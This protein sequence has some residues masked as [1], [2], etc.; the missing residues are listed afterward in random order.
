MLTY[1]Y[2]PKDTLGISFDGFRIL[3][4]SNDLT[5]EFHTETMVLNYVDLASDHL[6]IDARLLN[7]VNEYWVHKEE[8]DGTLIPF[9]YE[10]SATAGVNGLTL[11]T[12]SQ[13]AP[14]IPGGDGLFDQGS[15]SYTYY[16]SLTESLVEGSITFEGSSEPV[17]GSAWIDRQYGTFNPHTE[18]KYEWFFLQLSN[19]MDL[20]I[21]NIFTRENQ[22][23]DD[24]AYKHLSVYVDD[25]TQY[26]THDFEL[27][28]LSWAKMPGTENCYA[29]SWRL[30]SDLNQMDLSFSTLHHNSEVL[31]PLNFFEGATTASGTVNDSSVTGI[32]FAELVKNYEEPRIK[33]TRPIKHWNENYPIQ[34]EVENPDD[35]R[36][37][38]FDLTYSTDGSSWIP[39]AESLDD[40]L[41]YWNN[42][43]FVNGDSC[44]FRVEGFTP[45]ETLKAGSTTSTHRLYDDRY[46][47]SNQ[48]VVPAIHIY[49]NPVEN[50]LRIVWGTEFP[51]M[52]AKLSYRIV[53]FTGRRMMQGS[54]SKGEVDVSG[55][56]NGVYLILLHTKEGDSIHKFVKK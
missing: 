8:G 56:K 10:L 14:L 16:Y 51:G 17:S 41:Y 50:T 6:H 38:L 19:G 30:S 21:W 37:L 22:Q 43:P 34:W 28:R 5:G 55:L 26:T 47:H 23:P 44:L 9:E 35:G 1:F 12:V 31:I 33:I 3:N 11:S 45:D 2:Y 48:D 25:E 13:K 29:Q 49:P 36:P 40:T 42:H 52:R 54:T 39:I 20:N 24:S 4:V 46:T 7:F 32:G 27:E 15:D 53:D 18:E